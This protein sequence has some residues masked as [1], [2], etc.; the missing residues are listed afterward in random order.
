MTQPKRLRELGLSIGE[1]PTGPANSIV[2]V[3]GVRV[4]HCCVRGDVQPSGKPV[5]TG[6]TVIVPGGSNLFGSPLPAAVDVFN[7][8]GKSAGLMQIAQRGEIETPVY[9]TGTLSVGRVWDAAM[10]IALEQNP[11]AVTANPIV[12]ECNDGTINDA[13]GRHV[14]EQHVREAFG[15]AGAD[16]PPLGSQGAGSGMRC[17]GRKGGIGSTSRVAATGT[18]GEVT[19]GVLSLNNFGGRLRWRGR[20]IP[21]P[22]ASETKSSGAGSVI[23][24]VA[25]GA[26]LAP[27]LLGRIA[28][29][30]WVGIARVGSAFNDTSGDVAL[31]FALPNAN[32][33]CPEALRW[34]VPHEDLDV[35]FAAASDATEE[36]VWDCLLCAGDY[37]GPDGK[38]T[39]GLTVDELLSV[40]GK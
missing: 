30:A 31:A 15:A 5:H 10:T 16:P 2:D 32:G 13:A 11:K 38:R 23:V 12:L 37:A 19:L 40:A 33:S 7:G 25:V 4:G 3:P 34:R 9:L 14:G 21:K 35:L 24:V 29:R 17:M 1:L 8:Y 39:A 18:L 28:R 27:I 6:V 22:D 26:P 36:S 20:D